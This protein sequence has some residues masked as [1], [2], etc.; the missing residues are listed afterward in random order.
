[1]SSTRSRCSPCCS[2]S[3]SRAQRA[4]ASSS[5]PWQGNLPITAP[6]RSTQPSLQIQTR[7][8]LCRNWSTSPSRTILKHA[9]LGRAP[10]RALPSWGLAKQLFIPP[11]RGGRRGDRPHQ[12][13]VCARLHPPDPGSFYPALELDHHLRFRQ[14]AGEIAISRSICLRQ[15]CFS[16]T[17]T[18]SYLPGEQRTTAC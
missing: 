11:W 14:T 10:K 8:I 17:P 15:T 12:A 16:T 13:L 3:T 5:Q 1:L 2:R 7:R 4:P 6:P 18:E 9:S